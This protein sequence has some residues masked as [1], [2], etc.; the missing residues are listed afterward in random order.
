MKKYNNSPRV[1][2]LESATEDFGRTHSSEDF[3]SREQQLKTQSEIQTQN[4]SEKRVRKD[5]EKQIKKEP[6]E[7]EVDNVMEHSGQD[8]NTNLEY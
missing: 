7:T 3:F 6:S 8:E 5:S 4:Q 1:R 2:S